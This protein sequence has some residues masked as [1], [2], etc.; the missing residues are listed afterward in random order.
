MKRRW[1]QAYRHIATL[2]GAMQTTDGLW[3][4]EVHRERGF[5]FYRILRRDDATGGYR[6]HL[7]D[8]QPADRLVIAAVRR[9][10]ADE[11]VDMGGLVPVDE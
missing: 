5:D 9:I 7:H 2:M 6:L 3:R 10:L 4:V 1:P 11:G 8:G